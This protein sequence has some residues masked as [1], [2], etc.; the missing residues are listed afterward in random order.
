MQ[1][2]KVGLFGAIERLANLL[3]VR[4]F[5]WLELLLTGLSLVVYFA[6]EELTASIVFLFLSII[7]LFVSI[8]EMIIVKRKDG[9]GSYLK[10]MI[11]I[12]FI[13]TAVLTT[14]TM[15]VGGSILFVLP[16]LLSV[17]YCSMIYSIF[18]SVITVLGCFVPLL[19]ASLFSFYDLNVVKLIPGSV[20]EVNTTLERSLRP[21][22]IDVPGTKI[23]EL[24]AIFLPAMLFV[25]IIGVVT[26]I[27]S[28]YIRKN[29]L[30]QYRN[31]QNT[32]E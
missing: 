3:S 26:C 27:I 9:M 16:I 22:I 19:F 7:L 28:Y 20:I 23:N 15:G 14:S 8:V 25:V 29:I 31:F 5:F 18:M 24:L 13:V 6:I 12:S 30:E 4:L 10:W 21:E 11:G 32:R 1:K 2:G 17:Q